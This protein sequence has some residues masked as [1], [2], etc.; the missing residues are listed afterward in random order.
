MPLTAKFRGYRQTNAICCAW[1]WRLRGSVRQSRR[2]RRMSLTPAPKLLP[3]MASFR[4]AR[5]KYSA[6]LPTRSTARCRH[7][8]NQRK[9]P[10]RCPC[11]TTECSQ[12]KQEEGIIQPQSQ[13]A[14]RYSCSFLQHESD[15]KNNQ[16]QE[17][18]E[19]LE[20]IPLGR[21]M[22]IHGILERLD[23][24]AA[25]ALTPKVSVA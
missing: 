18:E 15:L 6:P 16:C 21:S 4:K 23:N 22:N 5:Q 7:F 24:W 1:M 17:R 20:Q 12:V 13:A 9:P 19:Q 25:S 3:S 10:R 14:T 11:T 8:C 2:L